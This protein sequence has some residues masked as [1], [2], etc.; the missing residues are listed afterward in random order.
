MYGSRKLVERTFE[1]GFLVSTR[2]I[3]LWTGKQGGSGRLWEINSTCRQSTRLEEV[4]DGGKRG[5]PGTSG[6]EPYQSCGEG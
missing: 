2:G 5:K 3:E 1:R 4:E 6:S